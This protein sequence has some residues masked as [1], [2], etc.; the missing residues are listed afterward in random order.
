M[1]H[2]IS[3]ALRV[4]PRK[5]LQFFAHY[6]AKLISVFYLG[7]KVEC[8]V[9]EHHYRKFLPFGRGYASRNNALCPNCLSLERHRMIWCFLKQ[10]TDFFHACCQ[11]RNAKHKMLH[12]APEY[13]FSKRFEKLQNL[14]YI[15]ADL[16]SPLAKIKMNILNIPFEDNTFDVIFCNHVF[17]HIEDDVKA[18]KE[19][20]RILKPDGWAILQSCLDTTL[21]TTYENFS[22]ISP[23]ERQK[24]FR[25]PD[26]VRVYG[27]DYKER[28]ES[29]GFIVKVIDLYKENEYVAERFGFTKNDYLYYCEKKSK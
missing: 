4:I 20:Y 9:C 17:E 1:K 8:P 14:D 12:I 7:N 15:T 29:A 25:Q 6:I 2:L 11:A 28:L 22:V 13:S 18:M 24:H 21:K 27:L 19:V 5:Y 26:H 3:F 23:E 16:E 10:K